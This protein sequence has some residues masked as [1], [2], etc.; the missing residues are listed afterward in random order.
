MIHYDGYLDKQEIEV[1]RFRQME[2]ERIPDGLDYAH[3][4][5]LSHECR[6]RLS[7]VRPRN[8]GQASRLS[9]VTPAAL[10]SLLLHLQQ[11]RD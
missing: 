11:M 3:V 8:L 10:T 1:R 2:S 5:G 6:Q 7:H 4:N 9:G